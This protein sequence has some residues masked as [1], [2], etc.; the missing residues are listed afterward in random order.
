MPISTL[1]ERW[2][3]EPTIWENIVFWQKT[4]AQAPLLTALPPELHPDLFGALCKSGYS[5]LF[6][7]QSEAWGAV[8]SGKSVIITTG[9]ASGKSLCYHLP[10]LDRLLREPLARALYLFPTKALA[11]DQFAALNRFIQVIHREQSANLSAAP[12]I[13]VAVYDGDTPAGAR[14][15]IRKNARILLTNPDMV[16]TAILPHHTLWLDFFRNLQF[17]ILDEAHVYRGVFGSHVANVIRRLKRVARYYGSH[18]VFILTSATI[19]NPIELASKLTEEPV[20]LISLDGSAHGQRN[21]ILYNP[22]IVHR[23]L[24]LRRSALQESLRL[25]ED[26][27]A[28]DI[29]TILFSRSRRSVELLLTYLRETQPIDSTRLRGGHPNNRDDRIRGYR[30]GYLPA[31]RRAIESGLRNG[32]VRAVV[33]TNALELGIDIGGMDAAILVGYPGTIAATLQQAGRAGRR[34]HPSLAILV[35]SSDPLDQFLARHPEYLFNQS[36]EQALID[37]NNM[38]ILLNHLRCAAFELPLQAGERF[39]NADADQL[40]E[41]LDFLQ[42]EGILHHS[43]DRYYW[44]ADQYP[45]QT[46]SLRTATAA[47]V[48]LQVIDDHPASIGFVD[49]ESACWL[50]HPGAIYLHEARPYLVEELDLNQLVA[51]LAPTELDYYT[52]PRLESTVELLEMKAQA[53]IPGGMKL[54]G[55]IKITAR[56]IGFK[57]VRW[58]TQEN[59]GMET[60]DLPPSELITSGYW[61]ALNPETMER[62]RQANLWNSDPNTYGANWQRQSELARQRDQYRCQVCGVVEQSRAHDVH[63]KVPLRAFRNPDGGIRFEEANRLDNL[64]TLCPNCHRRA[65]AVVRIRTG[66][67]GLAYVVSRIAPLFLMCDPHDLGVHYDPRSPLT[68]GS[69]CVVLYDRIPAGVGFSDRLYDLHELLLN[70]CYE[71]VR[72]CPCDNGCPSCVGPAGE[73]GVGGKAETLALLSCLV[74]E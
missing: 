28:D 37:S 15:A 23:E 35:A 62:L 12:S 63:H 21:F 33:A 13:P 69:P 64:I 36:P 42:A 43:E 34:E 9:P 65:E 38:V 53:P 55:E 22:P 54:L 16:H 60:L 5:N 47:Q 58:F 71:L 10:V 67:A 1:I 4:S 17:I 59:L 41:M 40:Q 2:K 72:D 52:E 39:G 49:R 44:M 68:D 18:P 57:K 24:G 26:L 29:Q 61:L 8:Q 25:A 11:Q 30:S 51:Y 73:A 14:P 50:V 48:V 45:A 56:V 46:V 3:Q 19:A 66:L 27:L 74:T 20:A 31:Q 70:N 6:Q 32:E 7:H